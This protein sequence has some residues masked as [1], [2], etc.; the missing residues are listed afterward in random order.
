MGRHD[1]KLA[2][3]C[4]RCAQSCAMHVQTDIYRNIYK[5]RRISN[6]LRLLALLLSPLGN[7]YYV[8]ETTCTVHQITTYLLFHSLQIPQPPSSEPY[9]GT[10]TNTS[11]GITAVVVEAN[12]TLVVVFTIYSVYLAYSGEEGVFQMFVPPELL[13]CMTAELLG[14]TGEWV[15]FGMLKNGVYNTVTAPGFLYGT[16]LNRSK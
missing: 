5:F 15:Y 8:Y 11:A 12:N 1:R 10:Y 6:G 16:E 9:V 7:N 2:R 14:V 4:I 3:T 13:P